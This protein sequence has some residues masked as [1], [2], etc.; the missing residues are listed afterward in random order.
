MNAPR[1]QPEQ[2]KPAQNGRDLNSAI[3]ACFSSGTETPPFPERFVELTVALTSQQNVSLWC[4]SQTDEPPQMIAAYKSAELADTLQDL[5]ASLLDQTSESSTTQVQVVD[6][7][8]TA[9]VALPAD[10]TAVLLMEC[11][12][13]EFLEPRAA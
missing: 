13:S 10:R 4:L 2:A 12:S 11:P 5:A 8:I 9:S 7:Y 6:R 1:P 3:V